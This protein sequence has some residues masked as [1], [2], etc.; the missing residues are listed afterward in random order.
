[1][2]NEKGEIDPKAQPKLLIFVDD[3]DANIFSMYNRFSK[4]TFF[5]NLHFV[6]IW[7]EP[8]LEQIS[9]N[10]KEGNRLGLDLII[11]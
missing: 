4:N 10:P 9:E 7:F 6:G 3:S 1:M 11:D 5:S 8:T 2:V